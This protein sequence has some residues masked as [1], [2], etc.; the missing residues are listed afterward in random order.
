MVWVLDE[1]AFAAGAEATREPRVMVRKARMA[2]DRRAAARGWVEMG[3]SEV[4]DVY[5]GRESLG[6]Q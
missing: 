4:S 1:A 6:R 3:Y 2:T 5:S